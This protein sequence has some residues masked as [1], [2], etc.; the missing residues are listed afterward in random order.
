MGASPKTGPL[1]SFSLSGLST[2]SLQ[3]F[4]NDRL[5]FP[6]L[7]LVP[8]E[9]PAPGLLIPGI[10]LFAS[11]I[12]EASSLPYG[13]S[14]LINLKR[15][16]FLVCSGFSLCRGERQLPS[17]LHAGPET[18]SLILCILFIF[19]NLLSFLLTRI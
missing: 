6:T 14:S 11:P 16:V 1:W 19:L 2:L 4:V 8:K 17:S 18:R 5:G 10:C 7:A 12:L 3:Q 15:V 13:L 9:F